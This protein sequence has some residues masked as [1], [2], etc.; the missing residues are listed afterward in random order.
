MK[1]LIIIIT[2]IFST[3]V[4]A[5]VTVQET[6]TTEVYTTATRNLVL[7]K[8]SDNLGY[9]L[10]YKN[11]EYTYINDYQFLH[12]KDTTEINTFFNYALEV[13]STGTKVT[14]SIDRQNVTISKFMNSVLIMPKDGYFSMPKNQINKLL[15]TIKN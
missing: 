7:S 1:N 12:F 9:S 2:L 5:Q 14:L 11:E 13:I 4:Y 3:T 8:Y 6:V 15:E 10:M